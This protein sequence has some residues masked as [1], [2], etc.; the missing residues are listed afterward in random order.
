MVEGEVMAASIDSVETLPAPR[1]DG[2]ILASASQEEIVLPPVA[3]EPVQI[4]EPSVLEPMRT[5]T[6]QHQ[7]I[8]E[9]SAALLIPEKLHTAMATSPRG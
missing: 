6:I 1:G 4:S 5:E 9:G 2:N 7:H 8:A 3:V